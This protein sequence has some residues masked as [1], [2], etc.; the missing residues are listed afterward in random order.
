MKRF[1]LLFILITAAFGAS[2]QLKSGTLLPGNIKGTDINGNQ[3]DVFADLAAGKT[4]ILDIFG[5]WCPPCWSFHNSKTLETLYEIYGPNGTDEVRIYAI[6]GDPNTPLS[7]L[8]M[9]SA[10]GG[11]DRGSLGDWTAGVSYSI[12]DN[13]SFNTLLSVDFFPTVYAIRPDKKLIDIYS[14]GFAG[15]PSVWSSVINP[16]SDLDALNTREFNDRTFC[17]TG[18]FNQK[19]LLVNLGTKDITKV[20]FEIINNG[21]SSFKTISRNIKVFESAEIA[22]GNLNVTSDAE[23]NVIL[24]SINDVP[25]ADDLK[26]TLTARLFRPIISKKSLKIKFTTD[27]YPGETSFSLKD[28]NKLLFE[29]QFEGPVNGGG[30]DANK[31]FEFDVE[32]DQNVGSCLTLSIFDSFAPNGDGM[33]AFNPSTHPTPGVEL[34]VEDV[35]IRPKLEFDWNFA[36]ESKSF[37]I[38]DLTSS[39]NDQNFVEVLNV[40]PNPVGDVL[41]VDL[42]IKDNV[43]Y[44]V[45]VTN[46]MGNT[47]SNI[48]KNTR[49]LDVASLSGGM[50]FLNVRTKEGLF[51][52]KFTKI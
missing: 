44:E 48:G 45:F 40:F 10:G 43:D 7:N 23:I 16:V 47:V 3:V 19:P 33:T 20:G 52:H 5:T 15:N 24:E 30:G 51:A 18:I 14:G 25:I 17:N 9:A 32:L 39:L 31:E 42:R 27:F 4:V 22:I 41:N 49:V 29:Y 50:Y 2:A 11:S 46:L 12:M 35:V 36:K 34:S 37:A 38:A 1:L 26:E 8:T 13:A 6:E 21:V 28:G